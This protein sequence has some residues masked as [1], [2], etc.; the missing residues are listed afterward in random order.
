[1][2]KEPEDD[3]IVRWE[4]PEKLRHILQEMEEKNENVR[5][6]SGSI[7]YSGF[8]RAEYRIRLQMGF[9]DEKDTV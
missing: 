1:M 2:A 4:G 3:G 5:P 9:D 6:F 7:A 8:I